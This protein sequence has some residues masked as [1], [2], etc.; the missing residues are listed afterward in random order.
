MS[1][2]F[3]A[4][5]MTR[6]HRW[7]VFKLCCRCG[8][9]WRGLT[10]DLSKYSWVEFRERV[11][12]YSEERSPLDISKEVNG[13]SLAY[14]HHMRKNKHHFAYWYNPFM[15]EQPDIPYQY[16]VEMV[17][18]MI[19]A[20][21]NYHGDND[22]PALPYNYWCNHDPGDKANERVKSFITQVLYKY[23]IE[24]KTALNKKF[25]KNTYCE[26]FNK[27]K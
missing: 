6:K 20:T 19:T 22:D 21:Q 17:C 26:I 9:F 7:G 2:F 8:L 12:Y 13:Y 3:K 14:E 18:D 5:H 23:S 11:K 4:I 15:S 10:H 24:G 27:K 16:L 25:L 1:N